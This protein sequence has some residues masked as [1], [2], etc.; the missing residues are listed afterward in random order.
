MQL[1]TVENYAFTNEGLAGEQ[2]GPH[3]YEKMIHI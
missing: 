1:R 3:L 2:Q